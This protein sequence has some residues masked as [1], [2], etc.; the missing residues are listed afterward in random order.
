MPYI[1]SRKQADG[2]QRYTAI[3]RIRRS[4]KMLHQEAKTFTHR[5]AAERLQNSRCLRIAS[6]RLRQSP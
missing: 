4:G 5:S 6:A 1:R 2:S 3:V